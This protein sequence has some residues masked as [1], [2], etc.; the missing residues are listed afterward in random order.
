MFSAFWGARSMLEVGG[1]SHKT[2]SCFAVRYLA[3]R[4]KKEHD[5]VKKEGE[6]V[7]FCCN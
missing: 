4:P 5:N 2:A 7:I 1:D 3:A 6:G